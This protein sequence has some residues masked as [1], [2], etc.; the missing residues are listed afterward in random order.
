ML[1]FQLA[2]VSVHV[3]P[4][5][6]MDFLQ[7]NFVF[8]TMPFAEMVQRCARVNSATPT[9]APATAIHRDD[10]FISPNEIY[11]MRR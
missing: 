6:Q 4:H 9:E 8:R 1:K 3:A 2:Q 10:Y 11:Y 7:R 5:A